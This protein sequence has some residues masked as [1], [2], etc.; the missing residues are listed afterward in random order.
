MFDHADAVAIVL[1]YLLDD[2]SPIPYSRELIERS[3]YFPP[4]APA[5]PFQ[6]TLNGD[7]HR[8]FLNV[9]EPRT[10]IE[11]R[12]AAMDGDGQFARSIWK[13]TD[14]P[15][16][17]EYLQSAGTAER[18]MIEI[19]RAEDGGYTQYRLTKPAAGNQSMVDVHWN[20]RTTTLPANATFNHLEATHLY[21]AYYEGADWPAPIELE[22]MERWE[23]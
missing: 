12:L 4:K 20:G 18:M 7:W 6:W 2:E 13:I 11:Q 5:S 14:E 22:F 8:P 16:P 15:G 3:D 10:E 9:S 23:S 21:L 1:A 17:E 19:R